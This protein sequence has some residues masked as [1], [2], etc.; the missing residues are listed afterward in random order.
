[1]CGG[2]FVNWSKVPRKELKQFFSDSELDKM[3]E[4]EGFESFYWSRQPVLPIE[5][6]GELHLRKW[7]N[8]DENL[9]LPQ[10]GWAKVESIEKGKW[11]HLHPKRVAIA[12]DKGY[13]KGVWFDVHSGKFSGL[14]VEENG[15][16]R[17]YV[18]TKPADNKYKKLTGHDREPVI[19]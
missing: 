10:T 7:G 16:E 6:N 12:V 3:N 19:I 15:D 4:K 14:L 18:V 13:E 9:K 11:D 5:Q 2:I 17:A 8:R 1:M